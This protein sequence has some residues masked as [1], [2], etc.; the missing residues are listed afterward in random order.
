MDVSGNERVC[1]GDFNSIPCPEDFSIEGALSRFS[2]SRCVFS[3]RLLG[4][5]V[6]SF[7]ASSF[8][9]AS[10]AILLLSNFDQ[11]LNYSIRQIRLAFCATERRSRFIL[12]PCVTIREHAALRLRSAYGCPETYRRRVSVFSA[13]PR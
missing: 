7:L 8:A 10:G 13:V 9:P 12:K 4:G 2:P 11:G 6:R 1:F 3:L 5:P